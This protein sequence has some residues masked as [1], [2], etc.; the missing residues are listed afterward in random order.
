[1]KKMTLEQFKEQFN[2]KLNN[3]QLKAVQ[4]VQNPTLLLAVPGSG[5][6]TVLV[7]RLGYMIYCL[8]IEPES[9]LTVTY[10]V[11]ATNYMRQRFETMFGEQLAA[12]LEFR[13]INGICSKIINYY[14]NC[15]GRKAF[16]LITEE[17]FKSKILSL[18][19]Q[20]ELNEYPSENDLQTVITLITYIKNMMLSNEEI[21]SLGKKEN[22]PLAEI[23]KA[24]CG[25]LRRQS[26]MDYDDQM[27]YAYTMLKTT[28]QVLEYFQNMY[29]YICVD[30]AQDTSKIQHK[31]IEILAMKN[32][33]LFM[34]GDEDQSIYGFRAAYPEALLSFESTYPEGEILLMEEN[35][36]SD[37]AIVTAA[38]RF[39]QKNKLRHKKNMKASRGMAKDIRLIEVKTR[40]SQYS[41]LTKVAENCNVD[42]AVLYRD[43]ESIIPVVDML[44]RSGI[45]YKIKNADLTF[46]NHKIVTDIKNIIRFAENPK[47]TEIFMQIYFKIGTYL[48]KMGAIEACRISEEKGIPVID[49]A[50]RYGRIPK[51]TEKSLK[52]M[53]T[54]I[55][56][57]LEESAYKAVYRIVNFMGY[58][59]YLERAKIKDGKISILQALAANEKTPEDFLNRLDELAMIIKNKKNNYDCKFTLSTIHSSKGL[60]YDTVYIMDVKDGVFPEKVVANRKK[61]TDEEIKT[62]EE[63][64]R[65]YY[66]AVT[67]AK[68]QLCIFDFKDS[69]TFNNQLLG[70]NVKSSAD[71][72]KF[73][74]SEKK[75]IIATDK[76]TSKAIEMLRSKSYLR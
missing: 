48:S 27:V 52:A 19:Y 7:T 73:Q 75:G 63:E 62:Y 17:G 43:N 11:A 5:K 3:Q 32:K 34:V 16:D 33:K 25:E 59:A 46:F 28:P 70:I 38:D 2:I 76:K 22:L 18:I 64:R 9:I 74:K 1:M 68:N 12:R 31:I 8:G 67:R 26:L 44:E 49:S 35:F 61:A 51:G 71:K 45:D 4:S 57:I 13:T 36:R 42:T 30:E 69:S 14:G 21:E 10:T 6:T 58:S 29:Q 55:E 65:L 20:K 54:H 23:Y 56:S 39:I 24:Y 72:T 37:G 60:E 47:D 53:K 66:V 15:I 40:K 50:L 41:Y